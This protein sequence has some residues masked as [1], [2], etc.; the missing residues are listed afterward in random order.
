[1]T[2]TEEDAIAEMPEKL[3]GEIALQEAFIENLR[4]GTALR[5][6]IIEKLRE[7]RASME[8][9]RDAMA[10]QLGTKNQ[11]VGPICLVGVCLCPV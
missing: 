10:A 1:L 8:A 9:T 7:E 5:D 3:R 2:T 4:A 11:Q 6:A